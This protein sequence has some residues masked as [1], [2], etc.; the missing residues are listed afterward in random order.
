MSL[1]QIKVETSDFT[2]AHYKQ[3]PDD[4]RWE[5]IYGNTFAMSPAP[6]IEHQNIC[7]SLAKKLSN[8]LDSP[9]CKVFLSPIDVLLPSENQDIHGIDENLID[10]IV[11]PD[12]I[13]VCDKNKV[14]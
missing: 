8:A 6:T 13:I 10:T 14:R 4:E 7:F 5:L 2:Y 11:Q 3:W 9:S 12:I 1:A